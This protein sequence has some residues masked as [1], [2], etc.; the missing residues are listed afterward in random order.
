MITREKIGG[1]IGTVI[2]TILLFLI[3]LFSVFTLSFPPEELEGIPVM[4]GTTEDAFG[5]AEP[6]ITE[7]TPTPTPSPEIPPYSPTE[8]LITQ[9]TEPTIDVEAE[10]EEERR[11]EQLAAERRAQE[12][13]ERRRREEEARK[14]EINRQMS[15]LFG[16][17]SGSRGNTEGE[18]TQGVSTGN[19]TQGSPTGTGGIGSYDLGG[20]SLGSGGLGQPNYTVNDYGTVVVNITVDPAGNVIHAEIGRGT[21]TPSATLREEAL[22]AARRTKFN[23]INSANNQQGTITYRF[24]LN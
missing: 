2:F 11:K 15:G 19:A 3:L 14:R 16:E 6:P 20:R 13:A 4:F 5:I 8:P 12:E 21:N 18:G 22:R 1:I 24:N 23:A 17:S 10:R 7:V 9:T